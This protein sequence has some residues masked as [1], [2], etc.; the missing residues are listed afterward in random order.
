MKTI[1][2]LNFDGR[3]AE[4]FRTYGEILGAE[5]ELLRHGDA[6]IA[7]ELPEA[8]HDRIMN[9]YLVADGAEIMGSDMPPGEGISP[10]SMYVSLHVD[11]PAEADRIFGV[12]ARGGRVTMPI[13]RT[14]WAERFGMLVDRFGIPWM[15]NCEGDAAGEE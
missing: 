5:P 4:A 15:V 9:A 1:P 8:W 7:D 10:Q 2:Y 12:L 14:I 11:S 6:P 13:E 3:C